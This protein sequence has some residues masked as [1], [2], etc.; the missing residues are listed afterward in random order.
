MPNF[1]AE[2]VVIRSAYT[3]WPVGSE[4]Y[5][6]TKYLD[7]SYNKIFYIG[8]L[9]FFRNLIYLNISY[10]QIPEINPE[11]CKLIDLKVLELSFN[12]LE[13]LHIQDFVCASDTSLF[14]TSTN[15]LVSDLEF[16]YL[17][18]NKIK[19]I[20][21]LDLIF[22]GMP[23]L[24]LLDLSYNRIKNINIT[25]ISNY[26][27][28][29]VNKMKYVIDVFNYSR[30][31]E[32]LIDS[33]RN[34]MYSFEHNNMESVKFNFEL[35]Y[36]IYLRILQA[37]QNLFLKFS[38]ILI[39]QNSIKCDCGLLKD[40]NFLVN[41]PFDYSNID[42]F[43]TYAEKT[44]CSTIKNKN[45][46]ILSVIL[47]KK[48]DIISEFCALPFSFAHNRTLISFNANAS[49]NLISLRFFI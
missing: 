8:Y 44:V 20:N 41:G 46:N 47:N 37:N 15:Y 43:Y 31:F 34:F 2:M 14:N 48:W 9:A 7:L 33:R 4:S 27:K 39:D 6:I 45:I 38:S 12:L 10:N 1:S 18:G 28:N 30:V 21:N 49:S 22:F 42:L 11:I 35:I 32:Q 16:L 17:T 36:T 40:M 24:N 3:Q 29:V 23:I 26:T 5:L 19:L 13:V 25:H